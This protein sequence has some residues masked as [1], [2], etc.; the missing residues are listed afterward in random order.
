MFWNVAGLANKDKEFWEG[1]KEWDVVVLTETW[2]EEKGWERWKERLAR[3]FVWRWQEA[4]R[5][6]SRGR[7]IGEMLMG[8]RKDLVEGRL[9]VKVKGEGWEEEGGRKSK[10]GK[11][12]REGRLLVEF[13]EE[14]GWAIFNGVTRRDEEGEFTFTGRKGDTV[15]D[16]DTE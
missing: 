16:K 6:G 8:I 9:A 4:T 2:T 3:E 7:A 14:W 10:D 1:L 5:E 12:N 15:I 11:I 13:L